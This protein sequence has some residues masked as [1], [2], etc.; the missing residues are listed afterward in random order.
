M[1]Q[2]SKGIPFPGEETLANNKIPPTMTSEKKHASV[3][4]SDDLVVCKHSDSQTLQQLPE[5][6]EDSQSH[7]THGLWDQVNRFVAY[8]FAKHIRAPSHVAWARDS[9]GLLHGATRVVLFDNDGWVLR[10]LPSQPTT[11]GSLVLATTRISEI[12]AGWKR[13]DAALSAYYG[14]AAAH[15]KSPCRRVRLAPRDHL[16]SVFENKEGLF[17]VMEIDGDGEILFYHQCLQCDDLS[18]KSCT[19]VLDYV[20]AFGQ[21]HTQVDKLVSME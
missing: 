12:Y 4:M 20:V 16:V 15:G 21:R 11:H 10:R 3:V 6:F 2:S 8:V 9:S 18:C 5:I 1:E 14:S 19:E 7:H 13:W 17:V